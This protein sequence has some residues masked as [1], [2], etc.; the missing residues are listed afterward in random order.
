[1]SD[2]F[3]INLDCD[4]GDFSETKNKKVKEVRNKS[5]KLVD[6]G[7]VYRRFLDKQFYRVSKIN[8]LIKLPEKNEQIR[9]I[10][11]KSFNAFSLLLYL[12]E[13]QN[14]NECYLTS[15]NIDVNTIK[16]LDF[17]LKEGKIKKI[18]VLISKMLIAASP[19]SYK[20]LK[21]LA[22]DKFNV[23]LCMNHTKMILANTKNK[24]YVIEGSG[25][26]TAGAR[27]E[28]YLFEE[29][30]ET[31]NFHKNWIENVQEFSPK[32]DVEKYN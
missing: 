6:D 17:L 30:Q 19:T 10:T 28:Q 20:M 26:L 27:I 7:K 3:D 25:N 24:H 23:I 22:S 9:I 13:S 12:L 4:F 18:T 21:D 32:K 2:N 5:I 11:Q 29:C 14:I 8:N 1:M 15:Y 16:G 31:Y